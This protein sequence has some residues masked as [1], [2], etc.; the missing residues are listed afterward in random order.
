MCLCTY[1]PLQA[2][3]EEA[4]HRFYCFVQKGQTEYMKNT[5]KELLRYG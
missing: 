2:V 4:E 3:A 1:V 5:E